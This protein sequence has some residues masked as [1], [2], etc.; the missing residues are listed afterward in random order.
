MFCVCVCVCSDSWVCA[1]DLESHIVVSLT[2]H[3]EHLIP[4][5]VFCYSVCTDSWG[6]I[7]GPGEPHCHVCDSPLWTLD[8]YWCSLLF[9]HCEH[10]RHI[11]CHM[12]P[13]TCLCRRR[14]NRILPCQ[15]PCPNIFS[16]K[17]GNCPVKVGIWHPVV[18]NMWT[19][20][21]SIQTKWF[22]FLIN[23]YF[24]CR[25]SKLSLIVM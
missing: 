6:R 3:C 19:L 4:I 1:G 9:S 10:T 18:L 8:P 22:L 14:C 11:H 16:E 15:H 24:C 5:G 7:W 12:D 17:C 21:E 25:L 2:L 13:E 23:N 20:E